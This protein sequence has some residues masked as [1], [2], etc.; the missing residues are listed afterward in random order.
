VGVEEAPGQ[1]GWFAAEVR[2]ESEACRPSAII[3]FENYIRFFY[4]FLL[5]RSRFLRYAPQ[6]RPPLGT[7]MTDAVAVREHTLTTSGRVR[8]TSG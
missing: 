6:Q 7:T 5:Q 3:F 4:V 1:A 2:G 8:L